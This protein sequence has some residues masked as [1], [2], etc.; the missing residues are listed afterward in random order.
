MN[1]IYSRNPILEVSATQNQ[2]SLPNVVSL[3]EPLKFQDAVD[4]VSFS[5]Y[6]GETLG[7]VGESGCGK[8]TLGRTI[9][10]LVEPSAGKIL[11]KGTDL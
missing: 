9:M 3:D 1:K 5:V 8:T 2:L 10:R 6:K 4:Q 11:Y 7:L